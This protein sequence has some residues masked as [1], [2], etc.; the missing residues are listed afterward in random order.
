MAAEMDVKDAHPSVSSDRHKARQKRCRTQTNHTQLGGPGYASV[1][2]PPSRQLHA[3]EVDTHAC[4]SRRWR[5]LAVVGAVFAA[6]SVSRGMYS[7]L[8]NRFHPQRTEKKSEYGL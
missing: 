8:Q 1:G 2:S 4:H 3:F 6:G 5:L 7:R